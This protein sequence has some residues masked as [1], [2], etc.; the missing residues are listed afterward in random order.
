MRFQSIQFLLRSYRK[1]SICR[2]GVK[3]VQ[4]G[5]TAHRG[6]DKN[7][8]TIQDSVDN[9]KTIR[10]SQTTIEI[11]MVKIDIRWRRFIK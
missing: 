11:D 6:Q 2:E 3:E 1:R 10:D 8:E 4:K 5:I 7:I 9:S